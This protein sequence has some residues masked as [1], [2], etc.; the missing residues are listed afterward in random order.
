MDDLSQIAAHLWSL[1]ER[2]PSPEAQSEVAAALQH[3]R[4]GIQS[5]AAQVLGAWGVRSSIAPLRQ[6][7]LECMDRESGWAVRGVAVRELS[8]LVES[9]DAPWVLDLYFGVS[10]WIAKHELLPL[11]K[12][13]SP[14][15]ARSRLVAGLHDTDWVN[16]HA[17]VKAIGNM[18]FPD[19]RSLLSRLINDPHEIVQ[20][21]ARF[22]ARE[23]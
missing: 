17:A 11:V 2:P 21:S 12:S 23:A 4:E 6:W 8:K 22:L 9:E 19:R 14:E 18:A 20:Q 10:G 15:A 5:V 1:A 13:L 3:K 16:R 7:F